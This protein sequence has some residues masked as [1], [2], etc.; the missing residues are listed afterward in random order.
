[1]IEDIP[2]TLTLRDYFAGCVLTGLCSQP[3]MTEWTAEELARDV[4]QFAD[5]MLKESMK[6]EKAE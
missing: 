1:M 5:A 2:Q 3:N 4:Y 6:I